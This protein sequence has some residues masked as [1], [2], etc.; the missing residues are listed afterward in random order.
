MGQFIKNMTRNVFSDELAGLRINLKQ[1]HQIELER[2]DC[3]YEKVAY[4]Q[5]TYGFSRL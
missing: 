2:C 3:D 4:I 5:N 1:L